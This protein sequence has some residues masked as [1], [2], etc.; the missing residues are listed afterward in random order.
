LRAQ[1]RSRGVPRQSKVVAARLAMMAPKNKKMPI[2]VNPGVLGRPR[3]RARCDHCSA[4]AE[5]KRI[6]QPMIGL[7]PKE[8]VI[9]QRVVGNAKVIRESSS[10]LAQPE[11]VSRKFPGHFKSE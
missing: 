9:T 2:A 11:L 5:Y 10:V 1:T 6:L 3:H 4:S 8:S 7:L